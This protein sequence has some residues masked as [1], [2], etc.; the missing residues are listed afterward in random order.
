EQHRGLGLRMALRNAYDHAFS[1]IVDSNATTVI[2]SLVLYSLGSEE[3]KGFGLTLLI[4]LLSSLFTALFVTKTIFGILI[5]KFGLDHLGS[6]PL[7]FPKWDKMLRPNINWMGMVWWFV[8]FSAVFMIL[9]M[10]AF[11]VKIRAG[12]MADIE[13]AS[14]TSVQFEL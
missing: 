6:L 4:G 5:D 8:G 11:V 9:G 12:E 7:S 2:T 10:V 14:G 1:A 3:V 13:F